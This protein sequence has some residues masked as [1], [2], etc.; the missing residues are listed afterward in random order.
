LEPNVLDLIPPIIEY[1]VER[2]LFP[3]MLAENASVYAYQASEYWID[4]GSPQKYSQLNFDLLSGN[5]GSYGFPN[6]N[7]VVVGHG[8]Q[9]HPTARIEGP[10]MLGD[11]CEVNSEAI[12]SGP[13]VIGDNCIIGERAV[14]SSSIIWN[15]VTVGNSCRFVSSIAACGCILKPKSETE[16]AILGDY[17]T[18]SQGYKLPQGTNVDPKQTI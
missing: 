13:T 7:D 12:I 16:H 11:N 3:T 4:I 5:G 18:I 15:N 2:Q 6:G 17:V 8:S 9:I 1:S 14:I 10:V